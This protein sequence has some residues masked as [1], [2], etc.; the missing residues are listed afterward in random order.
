MK[1][2]LGRI[3]RVTAAIK[4]QFLVASCKLF[5]LSVNNLLSKWGGIKN[6]KLVGRVRV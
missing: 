2:K 4:L 6:T 3:A 5:V 1:Q